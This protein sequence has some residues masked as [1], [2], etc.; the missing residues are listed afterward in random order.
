MLPS[1]LGCETPLSNPPNSR[2]IIVNQIFT[3]YWDERNWVLPSE[4]VDPGGSGFVGS[5]TTFHDAYMYW[6]FDPDSMDKDDT[7]VFPLTRVPSGQGTY[8]WSGKL[9]NGSYITPG[10]YS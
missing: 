3:P 8:W 7:V 6:Y 2:L 4:P 10:N 5:A 1:A 9:V